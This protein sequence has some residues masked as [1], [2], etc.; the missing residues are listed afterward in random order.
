MLALGLT[1]F[2]D[3]YYDDITSPEQ[4]KDMYEH[5]S[6]AKCKGLRD[7]SAIALGIRG[8]M[9]SDNQLRITL[10]SMSLQEFPNERPSPCYALVITMRESKTNYHGKTE[11]LIVMR[12]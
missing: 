10:S 7:L 8:V 2:P 6:G 9:R 4:M 11:Y 3:T 12:H 1:C 5:S